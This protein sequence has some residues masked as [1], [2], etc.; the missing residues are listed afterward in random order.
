[1]LRPDHRGA[2]MGPDFVP[3]SCSAVRLFHV[4]DRLWCGA[5]LLLGCSPVLHEGFG[6][7]IPL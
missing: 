4:G 6:H 3:H 2:L 7:Q 1:M 5:E